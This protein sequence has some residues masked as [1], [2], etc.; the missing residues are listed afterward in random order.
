DDGFHGIGGGTRGHRSRT[1]E[2]A[3]HEMKPLVLGLDA[4]QIEM[5]VLRLSR[6]VFA[7]GGQIKMCAISALE[8]ACWDAIGKA[9]GQPIYNLVGGRVHE[10]IPAYVNGWYRV[11]RT[12]EAFAQAAKKVVAKGYFAMKFDPFGSAMTRLS[13]QDRS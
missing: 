9:V 12:P 13:P 11:P 3:V 7:D 10:R 5:L 8:I 2:A 1:V 6:N 4:F